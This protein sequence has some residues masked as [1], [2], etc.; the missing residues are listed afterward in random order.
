[1]DGKLPQSVARFFWSQKPRPR[2]QL[3]EHLAK[4]LRMRHN[5]ADRLVD[6]LIAGYCLRIVERPAGGS[7]T[8]LIDEPWLAPD[9]N[10]TQLL[11]SS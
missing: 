5:G 8:E 6:H 7:G 2:R 3:I 11:R 10:F 4:S 9:W 1:M